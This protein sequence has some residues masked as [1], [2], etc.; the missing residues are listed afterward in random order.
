MIDATP[1]T[2][3]RIRTAEALNEALRG[4]NAAMERLT[5]RQRKARGSIIARNYAAELATLRVQH[6][7]SCLAALNAWGQAE[8]VLE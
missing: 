5:P 4:Q 1:H 2:T 3:Q 8:R 6:T 7:A